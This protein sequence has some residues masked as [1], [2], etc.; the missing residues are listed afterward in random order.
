MRTT[1]NTPWQIKNRLRTLGSACA[2]A[3]LGAIPLSAE[4]PYV[5]WAK[6]VAGGVG[7]LAVTGDGGLVDYRSDGTLRKF[8]PQG[9]LEL[10]NSNSLAGVYRAAVKT[11]AL[12]NQYWIGQVY[13]NGTFDFPAVRGFFVAK[14]GLTN[15]LLWVRNNEIPEEN[16]SVTYPTCISLDSAGNIAVG[17]T[18]KGGLK[19]GS[20]ESDGEWSP[21]FCKYDANGNLLWAR[22]VASQPINSYSTSCS[23]IALDGSG[24][25]I[26]CGSL[27]EGSSDFGGTTVNPGT[28]HGYGGDWFI[29]KYDLNGELLWVT[30]DYAKSLAVDKHGD[31]YVVFE[32]PKQDVTGIAKLNGN[33][34]LLWQRNLPVYVMSYGIALDEQGQPVF[35]GQ[36]QGTVQFDAIT[37]RSTRGW[38]DFFVAKADVAGNVLWAIAGGGSEDDGGASVRCDSVG[39]VFLTAYIGSPG[40]FDGIS[41][42]PIPTEPSYTTVVARLSERPPMQMARSAGGVQLSWPAKATNYVLE[43]ATSLPGIT[44]NPVTNTP[45]VSG[46]ERNLQLPA[47]GAAKFFRLRRP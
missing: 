26:A 1:I 47:T 36:F 28:V 2:L 34:D 18:S 7:D 30:L 31:I 33:G 25:V 17:G 43:A 21:L 6:T 15:N 5:H 38:V 9:D 39:N 41:I 13:T 46:R 22:K 29:A 3:W 11:D 19:L 45:T 40:S 37:L 42:V 27:R 20:F 23:G 16:G 4:E 10:A 14:F 32:W 44:W 35:A 12:G 24:N 8:S